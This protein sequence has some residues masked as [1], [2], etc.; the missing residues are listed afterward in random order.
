MIEDLTNIKVGDK[1]VLSAR[2]CRD[3]IATVKEITPKGNIKVGNK[4][5]RP[6]GVER[7]TDRWGKSYIRLATAHDME[8]ITKQNAI[9]KCIDRLHDVKALTYEQAIEIAKIMNWDLPK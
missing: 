9:C 1:V 5:F 7:T 3:T 8:I 6:S 4:L 2:F